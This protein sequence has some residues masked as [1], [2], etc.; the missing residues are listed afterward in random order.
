MSTDF[1]DS[2][3]FDSASANG[4][5]RPG[6]ARWLPYVFGKLIQAEAGPIIPGEEHRCTGLS[7]GFPSE[8]RKLC[9]PTRHGLGTDDLFRWDKFP[10]NERGGIVVRSYPVDGTPWMLAARIRG[11][12]ESGEGRPGRIYT[13][14]LYMALPA[15]QF[16]PGQLVAL[17]AAL[18]AKPMLQ[19]ASGM[20]PVP[21]A[22]DDIELPVDW[23]E[24]ISPIL[25]IVMSQQPISQQDW[26]TQ[27]PDGMQT[28]MLCLAALPGTL[29]WRIGFG[30]GLAR[31]Q[32]DIAIGI[33]MTAV[34]GVRV[35]NN[36]PR[37]AADFDLSPGKDY[38]AWLRDNCSDCSSLSELIARIADLLPAFAAFDAVALDVPWQETVESVVGMAVESARYKLLEEWL[39]N[40]HTEQAPSLRFRLLAGKA[41]R[42]MLEQVNER[43]A[44]LIPAAL[45]SF[46]KEVW[47]AQTNGASKVAGIAKALCVSRFGEPGGSSNSVL[48][49]LFDIEFPEQ[50]TEVLTEALAQAIR[51]ARADQHSDKRFVD[52]YLLDP[53]PNWLHLAREALQ[54]ALAWLAYDLDSK[55]FSRLWTMLGDNNPTHA[56][57]ATFNDPKKLQPPAVLQKMAREVVHARPS[58]LQPLLDHLV[59]VNP[60]AALGMMAGDREEHSLTD[61][62][63]GRVNVRLLGE[64]LI[65]SE[66]LDDWLGHPPILRAVLTRWPEFTG[67]ERLELQTALSPLLGQPFAYMFLNDPGSFSAGQ[68]FEEARDIATQVMQRDGR[69]LN[70]LWERLIDNDGRE[71][72]ERTLLCDCLKQ[73]QLDVDSLSQSLRFLALACR[74]GQ[75]VFPKNVYREKERGWIRWSLENCCDSL[76]LRWLADQATELHDWALF[77]TLISSKDEPFEPSPS[78]LRVLMK[79]YVDIREAE[80]ATR[81]KTLKW[82][83]TPGWRLL[84]EEPKVKRF[85]ETEQNVLTG[86]P[87]TALFAFIAS[88]GRPPSGKLN[89][90]QP[91][92]LSHLEGVYNLSLV[93]QLADAL[94]ADKKKSPAGLAL[95]TL[96]AVSKI[97]GPVFL[98]IQEQKLKKPGWFSLGSGDPDKRLAEVARKLWEGN[99]SEAKAWVLNDWRHH[100]SGARKL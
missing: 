43:G 13:Q 31:M 86:L 9:H 85:T 55:G 41:L 45:D 70:Q 61:R 28:C 18:E 77:A 72:V 91:E 56:A 3:Q 100:R 50:M 96:W 16:H 33:G 19:L 29:R 38:C 22:V 57:L 48:E 65:A 39:Q 7:D 14:A 54:G 25:E 6:A 79:L 92:D 26:K 73:P 5:A 12:S 2:G 15:S 34:G 74:G 59:E 68:L 64:Q 35:I 23:I 89:E 75:P 99:S 81:L 44:E 4:S 67:I 8:L 90:L 76:D 97:D 95:L 36:Q 47:L 10:W 53:V 51:N 84:M 24:R 87:I 66:N 52:F 30:V 60:L 49:P 58:T 63:L 40:N 32:G 69:P 1:Q 42:L 37:N 93:E 80:I 83:T 98:D 17:E 71:Q 78:Q 46:D 94:L 88:G 82:D 11:R 20:S 62:R 27:T 21:I